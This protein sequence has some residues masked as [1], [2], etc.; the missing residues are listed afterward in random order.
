MRALLR[1][2]QLFAS[3][4]NSIGTSARIETRSYLSDV[5]R[6]RREYAR[7]IELTDEQAGL[8]SGSGSLYG[9]W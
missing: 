5:Y 8:C 9:S 3:L 7:A 6:R 2:D 4:G 1:A